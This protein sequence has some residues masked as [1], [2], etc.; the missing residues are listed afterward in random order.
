MIS[1]N[2]SKMLVS[3]APIVQSLPNAVPVVKMLLLCTQKKGPCA[4]PCYITI[5]LY[6]VFLTRWFCLI[7]WIRSPVHLSTFAQ[8]SSTSKW[9]QMN[10]LIYYCGILADLVVADLNPD[11]TPPLEPLHQI[12]RKSNTVSDS[13]LSGRTLCFSLPFV[14][15]AR[16]PP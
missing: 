2:V 7:H 16:R 14:H 12:Q 1:P 15:K 11:R 4:L 13:L 10:V 9:C 6:D 8:F 5:N 3:G